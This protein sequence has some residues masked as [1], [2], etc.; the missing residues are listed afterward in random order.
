[1]KYLRVKTEL[2]ETS[3]AETTVDLVGLA[4]EVLALS[5]ENFSAV[6]N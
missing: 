5:E 6:L 4:K 2:V 1:M 3:F